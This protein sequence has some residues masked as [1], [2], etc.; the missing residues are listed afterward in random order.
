M[1]AWF[2]GPDG[3]AAIFTDPAD[4]PEGWADAPGKAPVDPLDHDRDGKRGG[5]FPSYFR[6][7]QR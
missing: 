4:I 6:S 1:Y 3:E 5:S 2:Y 7:F